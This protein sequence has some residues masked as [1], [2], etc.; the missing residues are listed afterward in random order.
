MIYRVK[1][2]TTVLVEA[3]SAKDAEDDYCNN[4]GFSK[5]ETFIEIVPCKLVPME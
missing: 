4:L 3:E 1:V 2:L 5:E